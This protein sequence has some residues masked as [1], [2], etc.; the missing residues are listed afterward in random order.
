MDVHVLGPVEASV[1][2][3]PIAVGAGKPRALLAMLALHAG[4]TISTDGL[5][6]GLWGERPPATAVKMVQL[7]VSQLRKTLAAAGT[8]A[9]IVTRGRGYELRLGHGE[10]DSRRFERLVAEGRPR[11]ALDQWRGPALDDLADEPFAAAEIRRL[12]ELRLT[13]VEQAVD[14]DLAAGRHR[15]VIGELDTLVAAEPLRERLHAQR[16]V[17]LYRSGRQ[18]EALAAYQQARATLVD[19]IGVEPGPELAQLQQA[20]LAHDPALE[21]STAGDQLPSGVVTFLLTDIEAS[22]QLWERKPEAMARALARHDELIAHVVQTHAGSLLKSKGEGDSTLSVFRRASDAVACAAGLQ[23]AL[24]AEAWPAGLDLRLR[25]ALHT[26]EAHERDGDYFGPAL[27]RAARLRSLAAGGATVVSH[28][29]AEVVRD[30][31]PADLEVVD[32]GDHSLRGMSRPERVFELRRRVTAPAPE[33]TPSPEPA[34]LALPRPLQVKTPFAFVGRDPELARLDE[35]WAEAPS[36]ARAV[37]VAGEPGIG[38]TALAGELARRIHG[39]DGLVLYGRCDEGL[40]VP[41]QP[42]VEALHPAKMAVPHDRVRAELGPLAPS[43]GRLWPDLEGWGEPPRVDPETDRYTLFEAVSALVEIAT[44]ERRGLLVLDDLHWAAPPTLLLLRHLVRSERTH[45]ALVLGTY[46]ETEL[47]QDHPL[48]QLAADLRRDAGA[49]SVRIAGL[50]EQAIGEM[51]EAAAGHSLDE[52]GRKL[53]RILQ[54]QTDGNPFFIRELLDYLVESGRIYRAGDR[55]TTDVAAGGLRIPE[56]LRGVILQRVARLSGAARRALGVASVAG[57]GFSLALVERVVGDSPDVLDALE[58]ALTARLLTESGPGEYAFVHALVRQT[59]YEEHSAS[60]RMR[61]HRRVG[62]ALESLPNAEAHVEALAHHFAQAAADGRAAKAAAYAVSAGQRATARLAF[63]DAASHY[64]QGLRALDLT[65]APDEARRAELLLALADARWSSGEIE[66]AREACRVAADVARSRGD[67][68]Q[69]ARAALA[70]AGPVRLELETQIT[71][72]LLVLLERALDAMGDTDSALR[73]RIM[74]RLAAALTWWNEDR[75]RPELAREAIEMARRVGERSTL[76]D[77][78]SSTYIAIWSPDNLDERQATAIELAGVAEQ[79]G[80]GALAAVARSLIAN[81]LL[82]RGD[83]DAAERELAELERRAD[84]LRQDYPRAL[85]AIGR[86]RHAHLAGRLDVYEAIAHEFRARGRERR[87]EQSWHVYAAQ[88]LYL[89]REQGRLSELLQ[90]TP[91][92][93]RGGVDTVDR[94]LLWRCGVAFAHAELDHRADAQHELEALA[95]SE[96]ADF[97][98]DWLWLACLS[99]LTPV[100]AYLDDVRLATLLYET[101]EPYAH[102]CVGAWMPFSLGSAS[103]P[104]GLLASTLGRLDAAARHFEDA[105][106]MNLRIRSPLWVAHT[107]HDYAR[108]LLGRDQP[109]DRDHAVELLSAALATADELGLK[110]L[111]GRALVLKRQT[112]ATASM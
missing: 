27:N 52:H 15:Q 77:V 48:A 79:V 111:T 11:E 78:L 95:R 23:S 82:E 45:R 14:R 84:S 19:Q 26:G 31:L 1:D 110:A 8:D 102:L 13:A 55:W 67:A 94:H 99:T 89:R 69:L 2:G 70:F 60:R 108:M 86:A 80:D 21:M 98:R 28:A 17:A 46:R 35:L 33:A 34:R 93:P 5:V 25:A 107:Q 9:E 109:G 30:R 10:V 104:L 24:A 76:A 39:D 51:L 83:I 7:F 40:A 20:I 38:K 58:E 105:L 74:G 6:E 57:H 29:T 50:D 42:F 91:V 103:R 97:P 68:E 64:A 47:A 71:E 96:F 44:R 75:R 54:A 92:V 112:D 101:I 106:E 56:G 90:K 36:G 49:T 87:D 41:Y 65:D 66:R 3:R 63:E 32:V 18:A 59:I 62:E 4:S 16:M 73:A 81:N 22:T 85:A 88:M 37:L 43:L 72:E 53:V 100:V 12:E 61:L